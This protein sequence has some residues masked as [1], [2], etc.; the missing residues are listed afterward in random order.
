MLAGQAQAPC[1][2][3]MEAQPVTASHAFSRDQSAA[4]RGHSFDPTGWA[5]ERTR[6][7]PGEDAYYES[8]FGLSNGRIGLRPCVDFNGSGRPG[9]FHADVYGPALT[10]PSHLVN[11]FNPTFLSLSVGGLPVGLDSAVEFVEELDLRIAQVRMRAVLRD[12]RGRSTGL[13]VET[14]LPAPHTDI[15]ATRIEVSH[16]DHSAD[17]VVLSGIDWSAGNGDFGGTHSRIRLHHLEPSVREY[18]PGRLLVVADNPPSRYRVAAASAVEADVARLD[19]AAATGPR[20]LAEALVLR[21]EQRRHLVTHLAV[22]L[23]TE[24]AQVADEARR[25]LQSVIEDGYDNLAATH[26]HVWQERW[27]SSLSVEGPAETVEGLRYA[28]FQLLQSADRTRRITNQPARG[29]TSEYHSGH[30]FFNS[31]LFVLPYMAH[32]EPEVAKAMLRFRINTLDAAVDHARQTGYVGAR[33]P[34]EA[35]NHGRPVS[36]HLIKDIF[37]GAISTENSGVQVMHLSADVIHALATYLTVTGDEAFLREEALYLVAQTATY[38]ADLMRPDLRV[39]GRGARV[40][41]GFD[42]YHYGVDHSFSTNLLAKWALRWSAAALA[43]YALDAGVPPAELARW[44]HISDEIYLPPARN[45]VIPVF[46]GYFRLPDQLRQDSTEHRLPVLEPADFERSKYLRNFSTQLVK[47]AD[48]VLA[49][50]LVP[51]WF[52]DD[53]LAANLEYYEPRTVHESS[54]SVTAHAVAAAKLGQV[55]LATKLM[56]ASARYNLDFTERRDYENGLHLAACAGAWLILFRG[57]LGARIEGPILHLAPRLPVGVMRL[58][59]PVCNRGARLTITAEPH[60]LKVAADPTNVTDAHVR[61]GSEN[62]GI[63][64]G[65]IRQRSI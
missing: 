32:V 21:G 47:Q 19:R 34:E 51:E 65:E 30:I 56:L 42:E 53:T 3:D 63:R 20:R 50:T 41:M 24:D 23:A 26:A 45:K 37:T 33:F 35:D 11:V 62:L 38:L 22:L 43:P 31:E 7:D 29:L 9:F 52:H 44:R 14:F 1:G 58:R 48:V 36:P 40:V 4:G 46:E 28:Q 5:I 10:V 15:V 59:M 18:L 17:V 61:I 39:N 6:Y 57:F 49:M 13:R 54:L 25:R 27:A 8:L 64:P 12:Q 55:E 16:L 2:L 60:L